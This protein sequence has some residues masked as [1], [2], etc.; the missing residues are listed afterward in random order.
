MGT[1]L[2]SVAEIPVTTTVTN[3]ENYGGGPYSLFSPAPVPNSSFHS[4]RSHYSRRGCWRIHSPGCQHNPL[5][6]ARPQGRAGGQDS[7]PCEIRS[8]CC[9]CLRW[10]SCW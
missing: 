10:R 4:W 3:N 2:P 6:A 7:S 5:L 1:F 8:I 9:F